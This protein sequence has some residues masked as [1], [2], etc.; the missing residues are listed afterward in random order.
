[1]LV[2]SF[3]EF[4]LF[5]RSNQFA[6]ATQTLVANSHCVEADSPRRSTPRWNTHGQHAVAC[7]RFAY[8]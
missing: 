1:M 4:L 6:A 2:E 8:L 5:T 7:G 3:A